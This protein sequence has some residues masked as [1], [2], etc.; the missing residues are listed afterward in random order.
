MPLLPA[1]SLHTAYSCFMLA[2]SIPV[3]AQN[4]AQAQPPIAAV[5]VAPLLWSWAGAMPSAPDYS[6]DGAY[7]HGERVR[8]NQRLYSG[9]GGGDREKKLQ[10]E[11]AG[12]WGQAAAAATALT[13][14]GGWSPSHSS[15]LPPHHLYTQFKT[16]DSLLPLILHREKN[17]ISELSKYST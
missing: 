1:S 15:H 9:W 10:G 2:G 4:T 8:G 14:R 7:Q 12:C 6:M 3:L 16:R 5:K 17:L 11:I 13:L